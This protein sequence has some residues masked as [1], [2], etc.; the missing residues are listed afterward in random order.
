M[1]LY[2]LK[3]SGTI[4]GVEAVFSFQLVEDMVD[5]ALGG[6]QADDLPFGDLPITEAIGYQAKDFHFALAEEASSWKRLSLPDLALHRFV[7]DNA[8]DFAGELRFNAGG[9]GPAE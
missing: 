1:R 5:V 9:D 2:Q 3:L 6:A 7:F 4:D 8:E